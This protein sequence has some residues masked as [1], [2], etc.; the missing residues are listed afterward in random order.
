MRECSDIWMLLEEII[1]VFLGRDRHVVNSVGLLLRG[2]L[3]P[4]VL[5]CEDWQVRLVLLELSSA[6]A[7]GN[8]LPPIATSIIVSSDMLELSYH[9]LDL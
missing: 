4:L 8:W 9:D 6:F 7:F 1:Q 3:R 5:V 2:D